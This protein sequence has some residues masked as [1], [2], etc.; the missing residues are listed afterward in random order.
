MKP[1]RVHSSNPQ[2]A[3]RGFFESFTHPVVGTHPVPTVPFRYASV[4]RWLRSPAPTLGQHN[5][6]ILGGLL[7]L[8][9]DEIRRLAED[10][11][12]GQRPAGV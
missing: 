9:D 2:M 12:I 10:G 3:A 11:V 7:G 8:S 5:R 1:P 6:E 4:E